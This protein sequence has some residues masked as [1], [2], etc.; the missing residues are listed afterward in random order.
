MQATVIFS[1]VICLFILAA[2]AISDSHEGYTYPILHLILTSCTRE[3]ETWDYVVIGAGS[4]GM[5]EIPLH[6]RIYLLEF[7][8]AVLAKELSDNNDIQR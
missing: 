3:I 7:T 8:G 1:S 2:G 4:A 5:I 6:I